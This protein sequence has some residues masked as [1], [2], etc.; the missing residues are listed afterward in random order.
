MSSYKKIV[1]NLL[2]GQEMATSDISSF[3]EETVAG[4]ITLPQQTAVLSLIQAKGLTAAELSGFVNYLYGQMPERLELDDALDVCGTGGSGLA[5]INTSTLSAF[6]LAALGVKVV[7]HG[8]NAASG[9]FGSFDLLEALGINIYAGSDLLTYAY[10]KNNL[11][12]VYARQFHPVMKSFVPARQELGFPTVF[13]I[14]GPLLNPANPPYQLIGVSFADKMRLVAETARDLGKKRVMVVRGDDGLDDVTLTGRTKVVELKAGDINE[15]FLTPEDFGAAPAGFDQ[16]SGGTRDLNV[17]MSQRILQ[18]ECISRHL[19]LVLINSA[20]ALYLVGQVNNVKDGYAAAKEAVAGGRAYDCFRGYRE[21][22]AKETKLAVITADKCREVQKRM[23]DY[24][25][26]GLMQEVSRATRDFAGALRQEGLAVIGELKRRSPSMGDIYQGTFDPP[27]LAGLLVDGGAQAISVLTD[28]KY[29]G[30]QLSFL[31][32][33]AQTAPAPLLRKDF[34]F[35]E[36]QVI[37][38]RRHGADAVLLMASLLDAAKIDR[39]LAVA[40]D[41]GMEAI[42]EVHDAAELGRVL[43][44]SAEIIGINNRNLKTLEVDL[45]T[46][47][48]LIGLIPPGKII[49]SESGIKSPADVRRL[50]RRVKAILVGTALMSNGDPR[51]KVAALAA[52]RKMVKICGLRRE[53]EADWVEQMGVDLA[54]L[55][56]VPTS[57]R[58]ITLGQAESIRSRLLLTKAVGLFRDQDV[59]LVNKI[60]TVLKLDYIQLHGREDA[61]YI[62]R[63][64]APVIKN[65]PLRDQAD[66]DLARSYLPAVR[67]VL[68]DGSEP[69]QGRTCNH[70]RLSGIDFP[71]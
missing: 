15:Y 65:M 66:I 50:P 48:N 26:P 23:T 21:D 29:F 30:G 52:A 28:E 54:G 67:H 61:D 53:E 7:K 63:C 41:L 42:V 12:F 31:A 58:C 38:A 40:R 43:T 22:V 62:S 16:V 70:S 64:Q 25:L 11:A 1:A 69:G 17:E 35:T 4:R 51:G 20:L 33:V 55:N 2:R 59:E 39:L 57:K 49:V 3:L 44:T 37:E 6:V 36:Y 8:N 14:L 18:G 10:V 5:R 47:A 60:T 68:F 27:A 71:F 56:F 24:P 13:N 32:Q 19:D 9:R 45:N 34:I 46:T